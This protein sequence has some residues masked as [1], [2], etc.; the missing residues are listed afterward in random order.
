VRFD[1]SAKLLLALVF[2]IDERPRAA[3]NFHTS[4]AIGTWFASQRY[5][6]CRA[7]KKLEGKLSRINRPLIKLRYLLTASAATCGRGTKQWS[8]LAVRKTVFPER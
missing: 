8:R 6:C 5:S 1:K 4:F 2:I 7:Y 3:A